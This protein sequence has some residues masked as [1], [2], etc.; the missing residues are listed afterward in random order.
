MGIE[1]LK[2]DG[3]VLSEA[4]T[5]AMAVPLP[6][7]AHKSVEAQTDGFH[8]RLDAAAVGARLYIDGANRI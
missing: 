5:E 1:G 2:P 4:L 3:R 8:Q 6:A 7:K